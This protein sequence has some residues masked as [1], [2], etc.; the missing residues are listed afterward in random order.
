MKSTYKY[1]GL[2][3]IINENNLISYANNFC[4]KITIKESAS[5][6]KYQSYKKN[7]DYRSVTHMPNNIPIVINKDNTR[8]KNI[9]T[10]K[11]TI[12]E[13][14]TNDDNSF[15][16]KNVKNDENAENVQFEIINDGFQD[17]INNNNDY[18]SFFGLHEKIRDNAKKS[19][20]TEIENFIKLGQQEAYPEDVEEKIKEM[21]KIIVFLATNLNK[22]TDRH[23][24][25][26]ITNILLERFNNAEQI[27]F[28]NKNKIN[29]IIEY[30]K[31]NNLLVLLNSLNNVDYK[32]EI[33][34]AYYD[35]KSLNNEYCKKYIN[36]EPIIKAAKDYKGDKPLIIYVIRSG[37][38]MHNQPLNVKEIDSPLTPLGMYQAT[39]LGEII[40]NDL[41]GKNI[42]PILCCSY[43]QRSQ[44][45]GLIL[46]NQL[47]MLN[48]IDNENNAVEKWSM[49]QLH[50][51][52]I[53]KAYNRWSKR[54]VDLKIFE[55]Y[56]VEAE[57]YNFKNFIYE[58]TAKNNPHILSVVE[59]NK[60]KLN[61]GGKSKKKQPKRLRRKS[62]K[63]FKNKK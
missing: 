60:T 20:K 63:H 41:D 55:K 36:C 7:D 25:N 49:Q 46:L 62:R 19:V 15:F 9:T 43:L 51:T 13:K 50:D 10:N 22:F 21:V 45:T 29:Q 6:N 59:T 24:K 35:K 30:F 32:N 56:I 28:L 33:D 31:L 40:K 39:K 27:K 52:M 34:D 18:R 16:N 54:L 23:L 37:N 14:Y 5:A 53:E 26:F 17:K 11:I 47:G 3:P 38:S 4:L 42:F 2:I 48:K 8:N 1:Q 57:G 61:V 58:I 44:L 12:F